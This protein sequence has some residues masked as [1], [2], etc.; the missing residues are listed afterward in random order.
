MSPFRSAGV[1]QKVGTSRKADS[2]SMTGGLPNSNYSGGG[3]YNR[4]TPVRENLERG[5][6]VQD[7]IPRDIRSQNKIFKTI[8]MTHPV[9]GP[10]IDFYREVP[11]GRI[12]LGGVEDEKRLA[13][14]E[15]ALESIKLIRNFPFMASDLLVVGRLISHLI[16][17][18]TKGNFSDMIIHD[19]DWVEIKPSPIAG[20]EALID[21]I[22][23]SPIP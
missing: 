13:F 20:Q 5:S 9:C 19:S 4:I 2:S 16:W 10:S 15:E 8:Y 1:G 22:V 6:I 17:D 3:S 7:W 14:Y 11:F 21:L 12:L 18:E 23:P